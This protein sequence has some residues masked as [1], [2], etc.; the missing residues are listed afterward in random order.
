MCHSNS[1]IGKLGSGQ[2]TLQIFTILYPVED[3]TLQYIAVNLYVRVAYLPYDEQNSKGHGTCKPYLQCFRLHDYYIQFHWDSVFTQSFLTL[4]L[5]ALVQP[6]PRPAKSTRTSTKCPCLLPTCRC[7]GHQQM[8]DHSCFLQHLPHKDHHDNQH[9]NGQENKDDANLR[10]DK[11]LAT[12]T[13][14]RMQYI[15]EYANRPGYWMWF[16]SCLCLWGANHICNRAV[17]HKKNQSY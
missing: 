6:S 4:S 16:A 14:E 13:L 7:K 12:F 3:T 17:S 9:S 5:L 15:C 10:H 11:T 2:I 1:C 8:F